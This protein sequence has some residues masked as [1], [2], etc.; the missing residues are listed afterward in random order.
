MTQSGTNATR[1]INK[2]YRN[3]RRDIFMAETNDKIN[4]AQSTGQK[5]GQQGGQQRPSNQPSGQK[6]GAM[7]SR[8]QGRQGGRMAR[9]GS[10]FTLSPSAIFR[11]GP[12]EL[13]RRFTDE[14]D[15]AFEGLG[16]SRGAGEVEAWSPSVEIFERENNLFVRAELPGLDKD[17]VKVELTD[18]GLL[19]EG[20]RRREHEERFEGGYRS[21]IVYGHF[22]RLIPLPEGADMDQAKAQINNGVLE[23]VIP[24]TE[25]RRP[26]RSI[27]VETGAGRATQT[28]G[29]QAQTATG[30]SGSR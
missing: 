18:D 26:S 24:M 19:I 27:P 12:F 11:M 15:R 13:M 30:G 29:E 22:H 16:L 7:Q 8:E 1:V 23:V 28:A 2:S 5:S 21:E 4:Q 6:P 9:R 20:D 3:R 25:S 17:D 14:L 10:M